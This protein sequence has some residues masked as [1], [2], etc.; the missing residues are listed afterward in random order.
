MNL[1]K[2]RFSSQ[3]SP[4]PLRLPDL[5]RK[6]HRRKRG[7]WLCG[8][9]AAVAACPAGA[10]DEI[11]AA[12]LAGVSLEELMNVRVTTVSREESTVGL[13]PAAVFVITPEMI[14]RSGATTFAE[15]LRMVPGM[16]VARIDASK[17]AVSAGGFTE[18]FGN[19]LLVQVDGRTAYKNS[20]V[21][22]EF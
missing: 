8:G 19:K 5:T 16:N 13:S 15:I 21:K 6:L 14:R 4:H 7:R 2:N 17:W 3:P 9:L 12:P 1:M 20:M 22:W 18:R 11:A 10:M